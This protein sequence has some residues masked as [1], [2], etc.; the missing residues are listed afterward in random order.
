MDIRRSRGRL[1]AMTVA[2]IF[3]TARQNSR[4]GRFVRSSHPAAN[5]RGLSRARSLKP[6][7]QRPGTS[8]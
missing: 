3:E 7:V 5:V 2:P 8:A 6:G 4:P 1:S